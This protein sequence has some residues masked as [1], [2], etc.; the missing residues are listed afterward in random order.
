MW[1]C[2]QIQDQWTILGREKETSSADSN[3][4][5][6]VPVLH[7]DIK[8]YFDLKKASRSNISVGCLFPDSLNRKGRK[9]R[10]SR[11]SNGSRGH[12]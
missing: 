10:K 5:Q 7:I 3:E 8:R 9:S 4:L 2:E 6:P 1:A 12:A 11:I